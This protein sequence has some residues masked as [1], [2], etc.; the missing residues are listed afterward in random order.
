MTTL[1]RFNPVNERHEMS[2]RIN[3]L[4]TIRLPVREEAKPRQITINPN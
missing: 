3:R 2:D 1:V 4:L